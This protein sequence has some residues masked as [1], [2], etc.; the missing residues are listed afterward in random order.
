MSLGCSGDARSLTGGRG[1]SADKKSDEPN[2]G[3]HRSAIAVEIGC[4]A[5]STLR[6]Q[7]RGRI[8]AGFERSFYAQ[9]DDDW[10]C[11]G[12]I[13]S[14]PLHVV[15]KARPFPA[16]A[17]DAVWVSNSTLWIA[18]L[19]QVRLDSAS[20]WAPPSV[21][22]WSMIS[23]R[24]GLR[25]VDALWQGDLIDGGLA[26]AGCASP[27]NTPPPLLKIAAPG[28][29]AIQDLLRAPDQMDPTGLD[30]LVGLGPGLTPSGD[31]LIGGAL[32]ALAA[33][34]HIELRDR[35]WRHCLRL[36]DRTNDISGAHLRTAALGFGSAVLHAAIHAVMSGR[37]E[38]LRPA[39]AALAAIGHT[40]GRD[41]FAGSLIVL[42]QAAWPA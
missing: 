40:S 7:G 41:T 34:G 28:L 37:V 3:A 9:L 30:C 31:D 23:L 17:G 25:A 21:P 27:G 24:Q 14:G 5:A 39:V 33:L 26:A 20:V 36:L 11:V 22:V 1:A 2:G 18:G 38:D 19:P 42:R 35:L 32:I 8:V 16:A 12:N 13:G 4:V 6:R 29:A 10:L 15:C